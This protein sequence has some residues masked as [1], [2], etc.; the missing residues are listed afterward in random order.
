MPRSAAFLLALPLTLAVVLPAAAHAAALDDPIDQWLPFSDSA[1]WVY[2]WSDSAYS[3]TVRKEHFTVQSRSGTSF[4]LSW[5]EIDPPADQSPS[6]GLMDFQ[7]TDA[8]LVNLNYQSTAPPPQMPILCASP[9]GCGN[10][11]A[12]TDYLL[13]WGTRS[14]TLAEPLLA[15]TRWSSVGGVQNDVTSDNRYIG[16]TRVVV[17]AFPAGVPAAR[18]DSTITQA[19]A[20]GDPYG[21]GVRSV[22]WVRGVGPARIVF[23]HSGGETTESDLISTSLKPLPLP[24]DANLLPL[25]RGKTATFRWRNSKHMPAWSTQKFTVSQVVNNSAQVDVAN[26]SGPIK[27]AGSYAFS[28]RL[29]GVTNLTGYTK[30]ATTA[31]FPT[32]GPRNAA[33][34]DRIHFFTPYD[35]MV[36]GFNP[37][38]PVPATTGTTW[39]SSR[40]GRDW[41]TYAATGVSMVLKAQKIKTPAG[42]FLATGVRSTLSQSG[43]RFGSGTRTSWFAAGKGLVKLVF[44]HDDGSVS[45]VE[46]TK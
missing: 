2:G 22:Y 29:S 35:L 12:G 39:R 36:Y 28:T 30:A 34:A 37:V 9:A 24:S 43:Y 42:T 45:T 10:S 40:Q 33:A 18:V 20:I 38:L 16:R 8:G 46:R 7:H 19:G 13:I 6:A 23:R 25:T 27:V 17:P 14:P 26:V 4:R 32:L 21:S 3:P 5:S 44:R 15:G 1:D 11:V 41:K 31:H